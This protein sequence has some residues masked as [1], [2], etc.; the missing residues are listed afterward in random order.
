[1]KRV[2]TKCLKSRAKLY[3]TQV[4]KRRAKILHHRCT[5][6]LRRNIRI[7]YRIQNAGKWGV[8]NGSRSKKWNFAGKIELNKHKKNHTN[9]F[10]DTFDASTVVTAEPE[11]KG[12]KIEDT[13]ESI[14]M[15]PQGGE[16][17]QEI[18]IEPTKPNEPISHTTWLSAIDNSHK[19]NENKNSPTKAVL[20]LTEPIVA[21]KIDDVCAQNGTKMA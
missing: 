19:D 9:P 18:H 7:Q 16:V 2:W 20:S 14:K 13:T 6:S 8:F 21:V 4:S 3:Q 15:H 12:S 11:L 1:M 17:V 5:M 10:I